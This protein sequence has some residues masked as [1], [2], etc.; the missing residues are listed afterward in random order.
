MTSEMLQ[1]LWIFDQKYC[2]QLDIEL[3]ADVNST[4]SEEV[5]YSSISSMHEESTILFC[6]CTRIFSDPGS[7]SIVLISYHY[8]ACLSKGLPTLVFSRMFL[9]KISANRLALVGMTD[10]WAEASTIGFNFWLKFCFLTITQ[11]FWMN[12]LILATLIDIYV[13]Y[14]TMH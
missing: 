9:Q 12:W 1:F 7:P 8:H 13:R 3:Q 2:N 14:C 11:M 6:F 10:G 5:V 4:E